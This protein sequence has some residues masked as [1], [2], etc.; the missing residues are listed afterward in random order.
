MAA[1]PP[2]RRAAADG[3]AATAVVWALAAAAYILVG[4]FFVDFMLSIVVAIA[5][6]LFATWLVP[7]SIRRLRGR[8]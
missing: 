5:Y 4:V 2:R 3:A 7:A 8:A 6:L 1:E